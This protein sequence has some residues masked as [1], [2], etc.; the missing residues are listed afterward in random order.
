MPNSGTKLFLKPRLNSRFLLFHRGL[1]L[2]GKTPKDCQ[3]AQS[4]YQPSK[5]R[6]HAGIY[7][8]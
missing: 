2:L 8:G 7:Y 4:R 6:L 3:P 1:K 5:V